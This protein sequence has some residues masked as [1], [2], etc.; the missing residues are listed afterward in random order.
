MELRPA[1]KNA[2]VA[3][4]KIADLITRR[5]REKAL[6][7]YRLL[8]HSFHDKAYALQL[9]GDILFFLNDEKAAFEKHKQAAFLYQKEQ[10]WVHAAAIYEQLWTL[11]RENPELIAHLL[12][13]YALIGDQERFSKSL[14]EFVVLHQHKIVDEPFFI[15]AIK[16]VFDAVRTVLGIDQ[17]KVIRITI[18]Q[19]LKGHSQLVEKLALA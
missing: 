1:I 11:D 19:I 17:E 5:E 15:R 2:S 3:W 16:N 9:E 10:K 8:S 13:F 6:S 18:E 14:A 4:F 12:M 7:V